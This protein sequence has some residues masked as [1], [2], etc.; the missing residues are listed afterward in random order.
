MRLLLTAIFAFTICITNAQQKHY[1]GTSDQD[2]LL[3][4][5]IARLGGPSKLK[6]AQARETV[7][8]PIAFHIV[9]QGDGSGGVKQG[10]ILKQICKLNQDYAPWDVVFYSI[11]NTDYPIIR[12]NTAYNNPRQYENN[13]VNKKHPNAVNVFVTGDIGDS[14]GG[15]GGIILGYYS[16]SND[17]V[18]CRLAEFNLTSFTLTH[19]LGHFFSLRH[20][21]FGWDC[22]LYS[23]NTHGNP[24][25][26]FNS[27]CN[28]NIPIELVN[29]SNCS[30]AGDEVC[31][32]P[33]DYNFAFGPYDTGCGINIKV[34]DS[35]GQELNSMYEN[36][37]SYHSQCATELFTQG[38]IDRFLFNYNRATRDFLKSNYVP[39]LTEITTTPTII[40]PEQD[41]E[42]D[43]YNGVYVTWEG[44]ENADNYL[45][46]FRSG[47]S[48]L[49]YYTTEPE[50]Y[51]TE[52]EKNTFYFIKVFVFNDG[53]TCTE[54]VSSRFE[55]G[56][57]TTNT[58]DQ[59]LFNDLTIAPNPAQ[60]QLFVNIDSDY[61]GDVNVVI[62]DISGKT[63]YTV[64]EK[65][66]TGKNKLN[67][68]LTTCNSG[69]HFATVTTSRGSVTQKISIVK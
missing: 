19:E 56:S 13:F 15:G 63:I 9:T 40:T 54:S 38:Q 62:S 12:S 55:T 58:I 32:T 35:N 7:Y 27:P 17:L 21:F 26:V 39:N 5:E 44:D 24:L 49:E 57:G 18:V 51:A 42:V 61:A 20:T 37:M 64:S 69:I 60:D 29:G 65:I 36:V 68:D 45:I 14:S 25:E 8:I 33:P 28:T 43:T 11:Y 53:Y 47:S 52:L 41:S 2:Q 23:E 10:D 50:F 59:D 1:C 4:E 16:P 46:E 3:M 34:K 48:T 67:I 22:T 66:N 30:V 6:H 31:D